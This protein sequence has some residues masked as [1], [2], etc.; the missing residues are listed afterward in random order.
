MCNLNDSKTLLW[1]AILI[2]IVYACNKDNSSRPMNFDTF[3][4]V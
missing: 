1:I 2:L 4:K 3:F